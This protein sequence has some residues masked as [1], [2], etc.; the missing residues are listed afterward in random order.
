VKAVI[1]KLGQ[2]DGEPV[3]WRFARGLRVR[4][5]RL[6]TGAG[7]GQEVHAA[8]FPRRREVVLDAALEREPGE[9]SRIVAHELFHFTWLRMNNGQRR[10]WEELI[11]GEPGR[12]EL[13]WSAEWRKRELTAEDR[14]SRTK[15]WREYAAE[16]FCDTGAWVATGLTGDQDVTPGARWVRRRERFFDDLKRHWGGAWRI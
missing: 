9:L 1:E 3:E 13:G 7:P 6:E 14:S 8:T 4:R 2:F 15:R 10:A 12:G 5:G 11:A 16:S